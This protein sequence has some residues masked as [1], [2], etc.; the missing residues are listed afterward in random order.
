[1][2]YNACV[3]PVRCCRLPLAA[4][5]V[6]SVPLIH[7][8][9][10]LESL[11]LANLAAPSDSI[12]R[13]TMSS[14]S[15]ILSVA[16][17]LRATLSTTELVSATRVAFAMRTL[18]DAASVRRIVIHRRLMS[19]RSVVCVSMMVGSDGRMAWEVSLLPPHVCV[20]LRLSSMKENACV[21]PARIW[22]LSPPNLSAR[23][24][25]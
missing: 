7:S 17:A 13:Q 15:I 14:V 4:P 20:S 5:R 22:T 9:I 24:V 23:L 8:K 12:A 6:C 16:P 21:L 3:Q 2:I 1:M 25:R 18:V 19:N 11:C 10:F